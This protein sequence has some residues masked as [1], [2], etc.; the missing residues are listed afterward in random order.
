MPFLLPH[1][2]A[3]VHEADVCKAPKN[4][5]NKAIGLHTSNNIIIKW[6]LY[7]TNSRNLPA[8]QYVSLLALTVCVQTK[9]NSSSW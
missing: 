4:K 6:G 9:F 8:I 1:Q 2:L 7:I 5:S 3:F